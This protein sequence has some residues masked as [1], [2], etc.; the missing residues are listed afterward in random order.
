VDYKSN[1]GLNIG[2][3]IAIF[4]FSGPTTYGTCSTAATDSEV[5]LVSHLTLNPG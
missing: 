1:N 5:T 2:L 4:Y 3:I